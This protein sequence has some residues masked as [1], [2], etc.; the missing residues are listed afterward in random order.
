MKLHSCVCVCVKCKKTQTCESKVTTAGWKDVQTIP[1]PG[2]GPACGSINPLLSE[3]RMAV[4][5]T[6]TT[7][8]RQTARARRKK[9][10]GEDVVSSRKLEHEELNPSSSPK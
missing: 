6:C 1:L 5:P 2:L 4:P 8:E 9:R 10:E 3:N 7:T